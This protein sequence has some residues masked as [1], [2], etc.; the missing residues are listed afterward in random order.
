MLNVLKKVEAASDYT[1]EMEAQFI[2]LQS[3]GNSIEQIAEALLPAS[4]I[5]T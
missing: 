4:T 1:P 3:T 5:Y 2:K